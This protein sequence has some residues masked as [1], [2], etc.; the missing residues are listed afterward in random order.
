MTMYRRLWYSHP[1][2]NGFNVINHASLWY[3]YMSYVMF[4]GGIGEAAP[5]RS[6]WGCCFECA[7]FWWRILTTDLWFLKLDLFGHAIAHLSRCFH[8]NLLLKYWIEHVII[9]SIC[10]KFASSPGIAYTGFQTDCPL[11]VCS[12]GLTTCLF[13]LSRRFENTNLNNIC[14]VYFVHVLSDSE[15]RLISYFLYEWANWQKCNGCKCQ[16]SNLHLRHL[17]RKYL[18]DKQTSYLHHTMQ[19]VGRTF[20]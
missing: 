5:H 13:Y 2:P 8:R 4:G 18:I 6:L 20:L 12:R 10:V 16:G 17:S 1:V 19:L 3:I 14:S 15:N 11:R 7:I 9:G